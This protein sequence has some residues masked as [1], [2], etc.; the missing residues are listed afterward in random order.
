MK[1]EMRPNST[2][3]AL[4]ELIAE[5]VIFVGAAGNSNQKQVSWDH[6]DFNNY[7]NTGVGST[8]GDNF[9]Y[10]FGLRVYPY[11]NRRGFP[12]H[13]G[14]VRSGVGGTVYTSCD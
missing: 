11:S 12:Q 5:G 3:Q 9:F 13:G 1:G 10:E 4:D 14:M 7:W 6:P 2:T 8:V